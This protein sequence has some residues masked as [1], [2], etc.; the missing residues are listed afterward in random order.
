M[1]LQTNRYSSEFQVKSRRK[2][3]IEFIAGYV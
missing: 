2:L 3:Q 1:F